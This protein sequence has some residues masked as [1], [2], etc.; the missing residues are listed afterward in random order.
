MHATETDRPVDTVASLRGREKRPLHPGKTFR[1]L[2]AMEQQQ[3]AAMLKGPAPRL[4]K[5]DLFEEALRGD[6]PPVRPFWM[7]LRAL[8]PW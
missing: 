5:L 2:G 6:G 1:E 4:R 7:R 3:V 8:L